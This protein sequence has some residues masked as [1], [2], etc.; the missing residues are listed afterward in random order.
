MT[1]ALFRKLG[2]FIACLGLFAAAARADAK[3]DFTLHNE[4]G[5]EIHSL[6]V[7]PADSDDWEEDVLGQDTLEQ[8]QSVHIRFSREEKADFWDI[9]VTDKD[10]NSLEW[11]KLKL[12]EIS[13]VTLYYK[14]G[15]G[16]AKVE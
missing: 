15:E 7:S 14:N 6:Y 3:Q 16:T 13:E 5:V 8:G 12:S 4:T 1:I 9:R 10:G 2:A 11:H